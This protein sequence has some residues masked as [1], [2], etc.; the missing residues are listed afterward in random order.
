LYTKK[1][2]GKELKKKKKSLLSKKAG[3]G[4]GQL[5]TSNAGKLKSITFINNEIAKIVKKCFPQQRVERFMITPGQYYMPLAQFNLSSYEAKRKPDPRYFLTFD[6]EDP[7]VPQESSCAPYIVKLDDESVT[8]Q[9]GKFNLNSILKNQVCLNIEENQKQRV[10][11]LSMNDIITTSPDKWFNSCAIDAY[12]NVIVRY[13]EEPEAWYI[14]SAEDSPDR[15][16]RI[17]EIKKTKQCHKYALSPLFRDSHWTVMCI[18]HTRQT[19]Y[20]L[21]SDVVDADTPK[22][23]TKRFADAFPGYELILIPCLKQCDNSSCGAYVCYWMYAFMFLPRE[24]LLSISC[25]DILRFRELIRHQ[26]LLSYFVCPTAGI[27]AL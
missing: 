10:I 5:D 3:V 7:H 11:Q 4:V 2:G 22:D 9:Y 19:I 26:L 21:N 17:A 25:P 20:Y 13:A 23:Q 18:D 16:D 14:V 6:M 1:E 27:L 24:A 12:G 15:K 8:D